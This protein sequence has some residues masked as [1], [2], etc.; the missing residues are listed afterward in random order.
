MFP[1]NESSVSARRAT[2]PGSFAV[3]WANLH[4]GGVDPGTGDDASWR[5]TMNAIAS[6][7][8]DVVC[9]QEIDH[10]PAQIWAH[11]WRTANFLG[12]QPVLGPSAATRALTGN[13]VGL[14]V[15]TRPGVQIVDQWPPP[16]VAGP[17]VPWCKV[18]ISISGLSEFLHVYCVHLPARSTSA[19]MTQIEFITNLIT[20]ANELA[21]VA[22]DFN[23]YPAEPMVTPAELA[24]LAPHLQLTRCLPSADGLVPNLRAWQELKRAGLLDVVAALPAEV[25]D[26]CELMPTGRG[27][28]RVDRC[29]AV[30]R[31]AQAAT[32]YQ[33]VTTGSD[34]AAGALWFDLKALAA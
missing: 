30:E 7:R 5:E 14:L 20:D 24:T 16:G 25:R 9:L 15:R 26:P 4:Y 11:L 22:G 3:V 17:Q 33:Q 8:P 6:L 10:R 34:H 18:S 28:A 32:R 12:M 19:Q 29:H 23:G 13:H 21:L 27:G 31:L 1:A 2:A